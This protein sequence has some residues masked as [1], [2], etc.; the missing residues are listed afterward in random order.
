MALFYQKKKRKGNTCLMKRKKK[1]P[2]K[3]GCLTTTD[4]QKTNYLKTNLLKQIK[5]IS[6]FWLQCQLFPFVFVAKLQ[7]K[8]I[9]SK[10]FCCFLLV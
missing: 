8:Q 6:L 5:K 3:I 1:T 4:F 2:K 10:Q 7:K 9:A